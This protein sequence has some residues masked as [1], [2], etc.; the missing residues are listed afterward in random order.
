MAENRL[1]TAL[2]RHPLVKTLLELEGNPRICVYLEPLW[3]I[4][5]NLYSPFATLFM[6]NL[7]VSDEQIGLLLSIGMVFQVLASLL[8]GCVD[9]GILESQVRQYVRDALLVSPYIRE[10]DGFAFTKAG[11]RVEARFTVHTVYEEFT[12]TT[13][14]PIA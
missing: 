11:S 3:G 4:P 10:V 7:G 1:T 2:K 8:G 9:Q 5:Y 13:E 6:Y 12:Q 14:V